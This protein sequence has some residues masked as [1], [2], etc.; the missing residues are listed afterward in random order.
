MVVEVNS[1]KLRDRR[2]KLSIFAF[3]LCNAWSFRLCLVERLENADSLH[4]IFHDDCKIIKRK[5]EPCSH[6][7]EINRAV[8]SLI[9]S[10]VAFFLFPPSCYQ[11]Q[12][13]L[14]TFLKHRKKTRL[15]L[16]LM[17]LSDDFFPKIVFC[18][19]EG[20]G[21]KLDLLKWLIKY[22]MYEKSLKVK[23]HSACVSGTSKWNFKEWIKMSLS[24][25]C[26]FCGVLT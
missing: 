3:C 1:W 22:T 2:S 9:E 26:V 10:R 11:S 14:T 6:F 15:N 17:R 21:K 20:Q 5:I 19:S 18:F 16:S 23:C 13:K 4:S 12:H 24:L 7:F 25:A 8:I